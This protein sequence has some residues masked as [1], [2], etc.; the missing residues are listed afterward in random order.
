MK[1]NKN[2]NPGHEVVIKKENKGLFH[3]LI[4]LI[5]RYLPIDQF[6]KFCFVGGMGTL[7]NL[8]ILFSSVEYFKLWYIYGATLAFVIVITFNFSLNKY[9]TFKDKKRESTEVAGQYAKYVVIGG[10]G[11]GFFG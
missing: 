11:M 4:N 2:D 7:L 5:E 9:W 1:I 6:I 3:G 8:F 10:I